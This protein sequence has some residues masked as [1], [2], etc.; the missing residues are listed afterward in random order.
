MSTSQ[1]SIVSIEDLKYCDNTKNPHLTQ[2]VVFRVRFTCVA[3]CCS[4]SQRVA[5]CCSVVSR[6]RFTHQKSPLLQ[7]VVLCLSVLQ[8]VAVCCS[9]LQ[10]VA[11][12][13]QECDLHILG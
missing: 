8:C 3:V 13:Y 1:V 7:S 12:W 4:V 5:D 2:F 6:V 9:V 10:T 11:V